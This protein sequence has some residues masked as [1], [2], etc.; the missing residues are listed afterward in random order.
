MVV[1]RLF[2]LETADLKGVHMTDGNHAWRRGSGCAVLKLSDTPRNKM[3]SVISM[4]GGNVVMKFVEPRRHARWPT[5]TLKFWVLTVDFRGNIIWP[6]EFSSDNKKLL[7]ELVRRKTEFFLQHPE[8]PLRTD[9][10]RTPGT[11]SCL[12]AKG[13]PPPHLPAPQ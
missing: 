11:S 8:Y 4:V 13:T 5:L 1:D 3:A 7:T 2:H 12:L 10:S 6:T 9:F